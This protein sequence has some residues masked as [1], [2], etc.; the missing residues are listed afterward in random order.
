MQLA[1]PDPVDVGPERTSNQ[2]SARVASTIAETFITCGRFHRKGVNQPAKKRYR[3]HA[4]GVRYLDELGNIDAALAAFN[5]GDEGLPIPKP[6]S[7]LFLSYA[8][9]LTL[10]A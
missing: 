1:K 8:C 7:E 9:S 6:L 10:G 4:D 2:L 3:V 5:F